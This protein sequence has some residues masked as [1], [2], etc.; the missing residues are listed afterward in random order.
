MELSC[1]ALGKSAD[2]TKCLTAYS[3]CGAYVD[4]A[5]DL[6][7]APGLDLPT[8][9]DELLRPRVVNVADDVSRN[10]QIDRLVDYIPRN[11]EP[12][13]RV[14]RAALAIGLGEVQPNLREDP[15]Q[16]VLDAEA[17]RL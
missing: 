15:M 11:D 16:Q 5:V 6:A 1:K 8:T 7:T 4:S 2:V 10:D 9:L 3:S 14:V 12:L 17:F 13:R